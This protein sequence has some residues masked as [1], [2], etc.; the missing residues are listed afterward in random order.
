MHPFFSKYLHFQVADEDAG[1]DT[2]RLP[3]IRRYTTC[4]LPR[5]FAFQGPLRGS[6]R[7]FY[8]VSVGLCRALR[9][10]PRDFQRVVCLMGGSETGTLQ[11]GTLTF[12][13]F[14]DISDFL[15]LIFL[16]FR[17]LDDVTS[18]SVSGRLRCGSH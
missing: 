18:Q 4:I 1:T 16:R 13:E 17:R 6:L 10:G 15:I 2:N 3:E 12:W 9:G 5:K 7:G 11:T 14:S 8:G